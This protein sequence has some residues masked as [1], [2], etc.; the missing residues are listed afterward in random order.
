[1][2]L[3]H[4]KVWHCDVKEIENFENIIDLFNKF[5]KKRKNI[6]ERNEILELLFDIDLF[7]EEN[8]DVVDIFQAFIAVVVHLHNL[9]LMYEIYELCALSTPVVQKEARTLK[10][11]IKQFYHG[12]PELIKMKNEELTYTLEYFEYMLTLNLEHQHDRK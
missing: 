11:L 6:E 7:K 9:S 5:L 12:D 1:M 3:E 10:R 4:E 2:G 8:F